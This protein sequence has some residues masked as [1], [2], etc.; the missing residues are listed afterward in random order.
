MKAGNRGCLERFWES[1]GT[2]IAKPL[3]GA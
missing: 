3:T 1:F 2:V